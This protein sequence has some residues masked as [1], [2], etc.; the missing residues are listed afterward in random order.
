MA[1][2]KARYRG[3]VAQLLNGDRGYLRKGLGISCLLQH[4]VLTSQSLQKQPTIL[5][6]LLAMPPDISGTTMQDC[7]KPA[8]TSAAFADP[9]LVVALCPLPRCAI[10]L[11]V[12]DEKACF[13]AFSSCS[14]GADIWPG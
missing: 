7:K 1:P 8:C 9:K 6:L 5:S 13:T 10:I 12:P 3:T 11:A 14:F 4:Q 2:L